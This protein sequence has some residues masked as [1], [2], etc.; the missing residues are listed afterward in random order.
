MTVWSVDFEGYDLDGEGLRETLCTVGNGRFATRGAL[1]EADA[2]GVPYPGTYIAGCFN[3]VTSAIGDRSIETESM[4]SAPNWLPLSVRI[5]DGPWLAM[6][7]VEVLE[8]RHALDLRTGVLTRRTRF[9]DEAGRETALAQRR[10]VHMRDPHL[11]GLETTIVAENWSGSVTFAPRSTAAWRTTTSSAI[12]CSSTATSTPCGP[13][14]PATTPSSCW[15]PPANPGLRSPRR[16]VRDCAA[17]ARQS[18][19][20][21]G[22]SSVPATS[23]RRSRRRSSGAGRSPSRR[24]WRCRPRATTRSPNSRSPPAGT[25]GTP[26]RSKS[27]FA[28][29]R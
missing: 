7:G 19:P 21:A 26:P 11:A 15:S 29:T 12:A 16:R 3:R 10:L 2:D 17:T 5:E 22:S 9:R 1:P 8:H 13:A 4:V 14:S 25:H 28:S 23:R 6:D 27:C 20:S 24:S 18:R